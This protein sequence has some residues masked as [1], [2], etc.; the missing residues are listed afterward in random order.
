M[1]E[2]GQERNQWSEGVG[3]EISCH[4]VTNMLLMRAGAGGGCAL[5]AHGALLAAACPGWP[6]LDGARSHVVPLVRP[7]GRRLRALPQTPRFV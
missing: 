7:E 6:N 5:R 3:K 4:R 1:E 2:T